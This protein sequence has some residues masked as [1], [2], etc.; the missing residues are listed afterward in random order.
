MTK[1]QSHRRDFLT[2][3]A[4]RDSLADA[5]E[6]RLPEDTPKAAAP[7]DPDRCPTARPGYVIRV[8]REA[9]ACTFELLLNAGQY[10]GAIDTAMQTLEIVDEV[11]DQLSVFRPTSD[12]SYLNE[13]AADGPVEVEARLYGLLELCERIYRETEGAFDPTSTPLSEVWG[14][15]R[16]EGRLPS[17]EEL[18]LALL[19][20]G[21]DQ[22]ELG[23]DEQTVRYLRDGIR[24]SFGSI[25]KG[26]ALD[27]C[28]QRLEENQI[29]HFLL[30]G[31]Y[32]SVIA[33]GTRAD[34]AGRP[35]W[36]VGVH[37]PLRRNQRLGEIVLKDRALATSGS[38]KQFF[39]HQGRRY[40]HLLNPKTG[41]PADELLSVTVVAPTA[42]LADALATAFFVMGVDKTLT[43]VE[44][45]DELAVLMVRPA[46]AGRVELIESG[47]QPGQWVPSVG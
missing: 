21:M 42:A 36:P 24:L 1:R 12:I 5:V 37:H 6:G 43:L 25:G 34:L 7:F 18:A 46:P 2:G 19:K 8:S 47:F 10:E 16:R 41:R 35:G 30:H 17:D 4:A 9:M 3:K 31:G 15:S 29:E 11:E 40:S 39:R 33:R 14:F 28:V 27:R 20:V 23:A 13:S 45:S 22:V 44:Q 26:Y 38:E 32:S